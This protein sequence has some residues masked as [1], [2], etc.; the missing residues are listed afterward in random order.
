MQAYI[1]RIKMSVIPVT[2]NSPAEVFLTEVPE[3]KK[4]L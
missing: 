4:S 3:K 2:E 1:D